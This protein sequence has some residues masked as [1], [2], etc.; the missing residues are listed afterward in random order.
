[1]PIK[2]CERIKAACPVCK[3]TGL[4]FHPGA[5]PRNYDSSATKHP[6][7][8]ECG[9]AWCNFHNAHLEDCACIDV[10]AAHDPSQRCARC[11]GAGGIV[12]VPP[13]QS[14]R[15]KGFKP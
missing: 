5:T 12:V 9:Q 2:H 6:R 11:G 10:M 13:G 14:P 15:E 7:C 1:M 8:S 4:R 3:G